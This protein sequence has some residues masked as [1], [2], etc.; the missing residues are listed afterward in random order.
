MSQLPLIAVID[1][2]GAMRDALSELLQVAGLA[3]MSFGGAAEFLAQGA[4]H[5][6]DAV[7][8]DIRMPRIDGIELI[9]KLRQRGG[10][11]PILV[12]T[13]CSEPD[14]R[15]RAFAAGAVDVLTKPVVDSD[16]IGRIEDMLRLTR[17]SELPG[18]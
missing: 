17:R 7:V 16:L 12:L 5:R 8:T 14:L 3:V 6:F 18:R 1:D 10:E 13:A 9:R 11:A 4:K 2:D 15:A